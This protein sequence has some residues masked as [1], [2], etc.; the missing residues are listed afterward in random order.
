MFQHL[1]I[2]RGIET[3]CGMRSYGLRGIA[4]RIYFR[5]FSP[6]KTTSYGLRGIAVRIYFFNNF[7]ANKKLLMEYLKKFQ[8]SPIFKGIETLQPMKALF[9]WTGFFVFR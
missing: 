1:P 5:A 6:M 2:F 8:N 7:T 4:V 9:F 3:L